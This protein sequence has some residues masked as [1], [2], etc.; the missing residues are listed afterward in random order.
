MVAPEDGSEHEGC[1]TEH[2]LAINSA[3]D[4]LSLD[5]LHTAE[6]KAKMIDWLVQHD[7][8]ER[9]VTYRLRDWLFSR[10]RYWGEP[11]PVVFDPEGNCHP[12]SDAGL[13]VELPDLADYEPVVSDEPQPLLA[14]AT[15]WVQTTAGAAGVSPERL[16]PDTPV[17]RETNT[18]PGLSLIHI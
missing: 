5:G 2:G 11:F 18:M 15:D 3:C 14:K 17:S 12:V 4:A 9:R 1:F 16:P 6:A 10:Q 8:G 13:P 7:C